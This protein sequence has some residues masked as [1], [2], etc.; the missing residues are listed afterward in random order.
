MWEFG[1]AHSSSLNN[2]SFK[3]TSV[4]RLKERHTNTDTGA[5]LVESSNAL[6]FSTLSL[7]SSIVRGHD[8]GSQRHCGR[9]SVRHPSGPCPRVLR[10]GAVPKLAGA[11]FR[12]DV[13]IQQVVVCLMAT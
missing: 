11:P 12:C 4:P 9:P 13:G 8:L 6:S 10:T 3:V 7:N 2:G 1:L 5:I